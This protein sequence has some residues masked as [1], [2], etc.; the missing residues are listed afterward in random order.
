MQFSFGQNWQNYNRHSFNEDRLQIAKNHLLEFLQV[1]DLSGKTFLDIGSGGGIHSLAAFDAGV[2]KIVS[3]DY[4][5]FSVAATRDLRAKRGNPD[6]WTVLEGSILDAGFLD[7]L[8]Q[9]DIVYSWGVLHHT[10]DLWTALNNVVGLCVP[11]GALYLALYQSAPDDEF[12]IAKKQKYNAA[13]EFGKRCLE[14]RNIVGHHILPDL[15]AR[16]D[17]RAKWREYRQKRGMSFY[18]DVRDW[19]GGWPYE[20][21]TVEQ[22]RAWGEKRGLALEN[23]ATE[24]ACAEFLFRARFDA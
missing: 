23:L 14:L 1:A 8:G 16:R 7:S 2:E 10:G 9:F 13:S 3:F 18:W 17:P 12:W 11:Q 5:P 6:N 19:L 15:R 21:C 20:I 22:V 24:E 4:D